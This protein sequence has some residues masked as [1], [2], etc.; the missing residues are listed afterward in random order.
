MRLQ[1][2]LCALSLG[3]VIYFAMARQQ[4]CGEM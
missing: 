1:A 4:V 3:L 2:A